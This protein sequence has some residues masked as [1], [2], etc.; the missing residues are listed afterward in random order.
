[1][2]ELYCIDIIVNWL[3][4]SCSDQVDTQQKLDSCDRDRYSTRDRSQLPVR[5][6][7]G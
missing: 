4:H 6:L 3:S 1:M 5:H 2:T 7:Q